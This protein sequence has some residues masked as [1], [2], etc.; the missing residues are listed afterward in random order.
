MNKGKTFNAQA[1]AIVMVVLVIA[2]I[3]GIALFSRL[4]KDRQLSIGQQDS[5]RAAEQSDALLNMFVGSDIEELEAEMNK[6][7]FEPVKEGLIEVKD[8]LEV[9]GVGTSALTLI[10]ESEWCDDLSKNS[11]VKVS[12]GHADAEDTIE[13][14]P[15]GVR[16]YNF[17]GATVTE[18]PCTINVT[19]NSRDT[20]SVFAIKYVMR[21]SSGVVTEDFQGYCIPSSDEACDALQEKVEPVTDPSILTGVGSLEIVIPDMIANDVVELRIL[22]LYGTL[23]VSDQMDNPSCVSKEF[24]AIKISAEVTCSGSN[25]GKTMF[26][27]GSGNLGYP[28]LFDYAIY[29]T[30]LFQ[31]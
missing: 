29:D 31:P 2:S 13:I 24:R 25:R 20:A 19:F 10:E 9:I 18:T 4:R 15:G 11:F 28:T 27:P 30:G 16:A 17:E 14:Q 3:I 7:T 22:P 21:D 1:L 12:L 8:F 6:D 23:A 5:A 26:L